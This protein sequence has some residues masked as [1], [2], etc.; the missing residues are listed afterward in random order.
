[1]GL[2]DRNRQN[3]WRHTGI[4]TTF[5]DNIYLT[6]FFSEV[7]RTFRPVHVVVGELVGF[8]ALVSV[9]LLGFL[10]GLIIPSDLYRSSRNPADPHR[11]EKFSDVKSQ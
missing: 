9:S 8:T 11:R 10:L 7:N 4:A 6:G 3:C 5:D 2:V 1:M